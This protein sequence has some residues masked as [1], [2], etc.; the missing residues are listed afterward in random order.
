M[1]VHLVSLPHSG[2]GG[3]LHKRGQNCVLEQDQHVPIVHELL[4]G[5][6]S[7]LRLHRYE[8]C[9]QVRSVGRG[10]EKAPGHPHQQHQE[11]VAAPPYVLPVPGHPVAQQRRDGDHDC[12]VQSQLVAPSPELQ[13]RQQHGHDDGQD[14]A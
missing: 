14:C 4:E 9:Q 8:V 2:P 1:F 13:V 6:H 12:L 7:L 5:V 10:E 3:I 11:P